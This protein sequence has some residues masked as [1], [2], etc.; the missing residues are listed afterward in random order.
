[1]ANTY[2][3]RSVSSS[4]NRQ[5]FTISFWVKRTLIQ[6]SGSQYIISQGTDANNNFAVN[7][8]SSGKLDVWDYG[9]AYN[10]RKQT[11]R[12]FTD[13]NGWYHIVIRFDTTLSTAD[14]RMRIYVNGEQETSFSSSTN[15]SQ[16]YNTHVNQS[17][18]PFHIGYYT[19]GSEY[20]DGIVS[21]FHLCDGYS[22]G[23]DSFGSTDATTGEWKINTS[24]SVS[25]GTNGFFVLKD[26]N[27]VTDQSG[28]GNNLT[29][30]QGTLTN[31]EDNPSNVFAILNK[32]TLAGSQFTVRYGGNSTY[33][34]TSNAWRYLTGT[35]AANSGKFYW[36][37]K[38]DTYYASDPDNVV[39]GIMDIDQ[40]VQTAS[41]GKFF[42]L[43]RGYGLDF[44]D[45]KTINGTSTR[46]NG[47]TYSAD[48][49]PGDILGVAMDLDNNKLYF[50]KNGTWQNSSNPE[51]G[52]N[53][54]F[55][56]SSGY[57]YT[58]VLSSY[59]N[60]EELTFNFGNG[61]F[62]TTA[63][64]SAGTNASNLGI[65]EYNVPAGYTALCTKGLNE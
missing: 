21:H 50:A 63:V 45:G 53:P 29:V 23:P 19:S 14:D 5:K 33:G 44:R 12:I 57:T 48:L 9:S 34:V 32:L 52:T 11:N 35:L 47:T 41:N 61:Y 6:S 25:Y 64:S 13:L 36:E 27:S 51:N 26:G 17:G 24:P 20:F 62:G 59:Y 60:T 31:T 43:S 8:P 28:Q 65:F 39:A 49:A 56:F 4:G 7:F 2:L 15:P 38:Y 54:A 42:A 55:T 58:P 37:V 16:N 18:N 22:Y 30:A 3:S 1:M 10:G 46:G 40:A